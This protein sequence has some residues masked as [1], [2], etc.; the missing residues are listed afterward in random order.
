MTTVS[1]ELWSRL[2]VDHP[3]AEQ[4]V[5]RLAAPE[6]S[7][8]F[9]CALDSDGNHHFLI[10]LNP[11]EQELTGVQ[12]RGL[13]VATR[14][15]AIPGQPTS[16]YLDV[17]CRD[18]VGNFIFDVI[19]GEILAALAA[20]KQEPSEIVQHIVARWKRFW[21]EMPLQILS[22]EEQIGLFGELW[23]L[24]Y[25][26]L[27]K[28][29]RGVI[30]AWRGPFGSRHDFE[31]SSHSVEIKATTNT[32]GRIHRING[33]D[34]LS[35]PESGQLFLCSIN[36]N[37]EAGATHNLLTVIH[38][39]RQ[40]FERDDELLSRFENSLFR[41]G[42]SPAHDEEYSKATYRVKECVLFLVKDNFPRLVP[43]TF[44][45]APPPGIERIDYLINLNTFDNLIIA[46]TPEQWTT[47]RESITDLL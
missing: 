41:I 15:L 45:G 19:G 34:Q 18:R 47:N 8:R 17:G 35:P 27:P 38:S 30:H 12:T 39:C 16:S 29:G 11:G 26:L 9:F 33:I 40:H 23:F 42:Y 36:L 44:A 2:A 32:R 20:G 28:F 46:F 22:R 43:D 13:N 6:I 1:P 5:A 31:W 14:E 10:P 37:E 3:V 7:N 21:G 4:L 24:L 25:W